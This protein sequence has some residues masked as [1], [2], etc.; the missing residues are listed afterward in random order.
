MPDEAS[1]D[2]LLQ[3]ERGQYLAEVLQGNTTEFFWYYVIH[4]KGS[5]KIID[6]KKFDSRDKAI[7]AAKLVLE[8]LN[9]AGTAGES[10]ASS[11]R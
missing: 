4:R 7:E 8:R 11:S 6:L 1:S 9:R 2:S 3:I 5:D 10:E